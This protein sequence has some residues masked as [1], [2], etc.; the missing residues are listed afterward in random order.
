MQKKTAVRPDG[1][2]FRLSPAQK[3]AAKTGA[4]FLLFQF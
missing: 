3:E 1:G 2:F 4:K